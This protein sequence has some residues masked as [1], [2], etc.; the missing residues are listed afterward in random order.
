[1]G[2]VVILFADDFRRILTVVSKSIKSDE[3][4][5]CINSLYLWFY[6]TSLKLTT[7]MRV[8]LAGDNNAEHFSELTD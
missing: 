4:N 6:F 7:N 8:N 5:A 2:E 1:M 3:I